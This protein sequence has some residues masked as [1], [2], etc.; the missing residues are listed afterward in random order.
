MTSKATSK[1]ESQ[2]IIAGFSG[3]KRFS[4]FMI[5]SK[6]LNRFPSV[7]VNVRIPYFS[8]ILV[9]RYTCSV[10]PLSNWYFVNNILTVFDVE[11]EEEEEEEDEEEDE[12]VDD[13]DNN[14]IPKG[15]KVYKNK[16]F[17]NLILYFKLFLS[18]NFICYRIGTI[19]LLHI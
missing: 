8:R 12:E 5:Y 1:F 3:S 11:E 10:D 4:F 15:I 14:A 7:N 19:G 2:R 13:V 17:L 16:I 9:W 6:S 18:Y